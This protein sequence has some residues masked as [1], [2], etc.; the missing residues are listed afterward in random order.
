MVHLSLSC[1]TSRPAQSISFPLSSR[2][3]S[4]S[5][6]EVVP[7]RPRPFGIAAGV[8]A[9]SLAS[10]IAP[11]QAA[12][13]KAIEPDY[14]LLRRGPHSYVLGTGYRGW[15][16]DVQDAA[17]EAYRWGHVYGSL[18]TC[19]WIFEGSVPAGGAE[20]PDACRHQDRIL[21]DAD[22]S[23]AI[24]GGADDGADV[25]IV[26][27][28][29]LCPT[30]DGVHVVGYGNV[31]PWLARS[32]PTEPLQTQVSLG[33]QVKRRYLVRDGQFVM[34]RDPNLGAADGVGLQAWFFL[35]TAC[36]TEAPPPPPPTP[37]LVDAA[38]PPPLDAAPSGEDAGP[39]DTGDVS[40]AD[41]EP[42]VNDLDDASGADPGGEDLGTSPLDPGADGSVDAIQ[43]GQVS[44]KGGGCV[45]TPGARP[46][47]WGVV[48]A[49]PLLALR[50]RRTASTTKS[51]DGDRS[52]TGPAARS[53]PSTPD[54]PP[55]GEV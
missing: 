37:P 46:D 15:T 20:V 29:A 40:S 45:A 8:L 6:V 21:P 23:S 7:R 43:P 38:L 12:L 53:G 19:L 36:V 35:P 32:E 44:G 55:S 49:L 17:S 3:E 25:F 9:L 26:G 1:P 54:G 22:F 2:S 41:A 16:V 30:W 52:R 51:H 27:D 50:R 31:R 47:A 24:Y 39:E 14:T 10:N 28:A 42:A 5:F 33:G 13:R 34:V 11:A 4:G 48:L 18:D